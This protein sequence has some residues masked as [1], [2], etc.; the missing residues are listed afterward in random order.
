[1][2]AIGARS[3][4]ILGD[5]AAMMKGVEVRATTKKLV[6]CM[7]TVVGALKRCNV[8]RCRCIVRTVSIES[9]ERKWRV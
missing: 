3:R 5:G 4:L 1:M 6:R 2:W 7:V 8:T 9:E